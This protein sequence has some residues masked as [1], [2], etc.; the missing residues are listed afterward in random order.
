MASPCV[1]AS[2]YHEDVRCSE[3]ILER[4]VD[5]YRTISVNN[6]KLKVLGVLPRQEVELRCHP[7]LVTGLTEVRFWH[8]NRFVNVQQ[9][10]NEELGLV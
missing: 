5:A 1:A 4:T 7:D 6:L 9:I 2:D 8:D 3:E 10:K